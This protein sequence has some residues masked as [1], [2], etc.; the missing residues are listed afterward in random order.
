[1]VNVGD[2]EDVIKFLARKEDELEHFTL[3]HSLFQSFLLY[4]ANFT[5]DNC[6]TFLM[7]VYAKRPLQDLQDFRKCMSN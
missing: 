4:Y 7:Y 3:F 2:V 6:M 1:M 5:K